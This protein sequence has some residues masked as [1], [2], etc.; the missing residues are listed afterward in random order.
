MSRLLPVVLTAAAGLA[1]SACTADPEPR[2]TASTASNGAAV[3]TPSPSSSKAALGTSTDN[4][5]LQVGVTAF[6]C[7]APVG[8]SKDCAL[9]L[10]VHN[11]TDL[12]QALVHTEQFLVDEA[13]TQFAVSLP[14]TIRD[15]KSTPVLRPVKPDATVTGV[16]HY[17]V[18]ADT[19]VATARLTETGRPPVEVD[20]ANA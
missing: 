12:E 17:L 3:A 8:D 13:G 4:G 6:R 7:A 2:T 5:R 14:Q 1:L 10:S 16:L 18:P 11:S 20:L 19:V 9:T 15:P